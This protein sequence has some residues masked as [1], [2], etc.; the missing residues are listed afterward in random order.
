MHLGI[1]KNEYI[2]KGIGYISRINWR[3]VSLFLVFLIISFAYWMLLFIDKDVKHKYFIPVKYTNIPPD[4]AFDTPLTDSFSVNIETKGVNILKNVFSQKP[5]IDIDVEKYHNEGI[6]EIQG[7][8]LKRIFRNKLEID[9]DEIKSY[10]PISIPLKASKLQQKEIDVIFNGEIST[11]QNNLIAEPMIIT[12]D[13]VI[14]YGSAKQ[15]E[16]LKEVHTEYAKLDDIKQSSTFALELEVPQSGVKLEPNTVEVNIPILVYTERTVELLINATNIPEDRDVKFF[17]SQA[18][19]SFS[20][21]LDEYKKIKPE[22]F[23]IELNYNDFY[24]NDNAKV[25][26]SLSN[27]PSSVMNIKISP[28]SV[29]FLIE[30]R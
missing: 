18:N 19:V 12:P 13:K 30:K 6:S 8:E 1:S 7:E 29:D 21:T 5:V 4:I 22:D 17:P 26:L 11:A 23:L 2:R 24:K 16:N 28:A 27:S 15:L 9:L 14:A 10:Y 20:V 3:H 25:E